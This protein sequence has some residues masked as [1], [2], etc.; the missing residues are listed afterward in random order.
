MSSETSTS[1]AIVK[2]SD[3]NNMCPREFCSNVTLFGTFFE[4]PS[5]NF[6]SYDEKK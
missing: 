2:C 3:L 1:T 4:I 6:E 5:K